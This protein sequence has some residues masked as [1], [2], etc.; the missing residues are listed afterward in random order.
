MCLHFP[1]ISIPLCSVQRVNTVQT[2][3]L[4]IRYR[5]AC[6]Q[7]FCN[8]CD[9]VNAGC[10]RINIDRQRKPS[11]IGTNLTLFSMVIKVRESH[12]IHAQTWEEFEFKAATILQATV[13]HLE[14][15]ANSNN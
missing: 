6:L 11:W 12:A 8:L 4:N 2:M 10:K 9:F 5:K 1:Y 15:Q 7:D 14:S 3:Y 13:W